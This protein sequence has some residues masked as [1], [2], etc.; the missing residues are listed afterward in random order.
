MFCV[1]DMFELNIINIVLG[2]I[3]VIMFIYGKYCIVCNGKCYVIIF[4]D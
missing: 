3:E 4:D 2:E 1:K